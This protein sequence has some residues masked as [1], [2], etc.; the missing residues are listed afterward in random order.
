MEKRVYLYKNSEIS[1]Y[2]FGRG[3]RL[4]LCFHGYGENALHFSFLDKFLGDEFSFFSLDLPFHGDTKWKDGLDFTIEDL[5]QIINGILP[6]EERD[7]WLLGFSLGGR[8][9][10]HYFQ[11][12]PTGVNRLVLLA[13]DGLKVNFWYWLATQTLL[14]RMLFSFSMKKPGW[15][16]I[17]LKFLNKLGFVNTSVFKFVNYYI[18]DANAREVLYQRWICMRKIRP[19]L[20]RIKKSVMEQ[21]VPVRLIYGKY[22]RIILPVRGEKFRKGMEEF[23]TI[24]TIQAGH[25]VL[26]ENHV[27]EIRKAL[28]Y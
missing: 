13:P 23:C 15:F 14:G 5:S 17:L 27:E 24:K 20:R 7:L 11:Q 26:H 10:L 2:R 19:Q 3:Q 1:Y 22:D 8:V 12:N 6:G 4:V 21:R 28:L 9:A 16:F 18:G 25:Q